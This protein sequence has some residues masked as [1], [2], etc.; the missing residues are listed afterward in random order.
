MNAPH[1]LV[2]GNDSSIGSAL[3]IYLETKNIEVWSTTRRRGRV[4]DRCNYLDLEDVE[5]WTPHHPVE[6]AYICAGVTSQ[7]A[8]RDDPEAASRINVRNLLKV[9]EAVK[10]AGGHV[11]FLSTNLVFDGSTARQSADAPHSPK[12]EYGRQK[13]QAEKVLQGWDGGYSIVR[14][15]KVIGAEFT[16][17]DT[18]KQA[19]LKGEAIRAFSDLPFSPISLDLA[20]RVLEEAGSRKTRGIVQISAQR[21]VSYEEAARFLAN[22]LGADGALV[23]GGSVDLPME[24]VPL[25]T[26]LD[27]SRLE[28]EFEIPPV[29]P[30]DAIAQYLSA[31][32]SLGG[33]Q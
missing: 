9:A 25:H 12:T 13:A 28:R 21:D 20:V 2:I 31:G 22:R 17:F 27:T 10:A 19:L 26:T 24:H 6:V 16:L 3:K 7:Q 23:N 5:G 8:C 14:L 30:W 15:T 32:R 33:G 29:N 4:D 1:A 11:V 18:W